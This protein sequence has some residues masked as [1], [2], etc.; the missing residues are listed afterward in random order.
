MVA[1]PAG[2]GKTTLLT[3]WLGTDA[4]AKP[5]P[6]VAWVSLDGRDNDLATFWTYVVAALQGSDSARDTLGVAALDVL[7]SRQPSSDAAIATLVN[8]LEQLDEEVLLVL[9]DYHVIESSDI[10]E[11]MTDLIDHLPSNTHV[12]LATRTDPPLPLARLR[13]R[14]ELIEVR[15]ADLRFTG[16]EAADYLAGPMGLT[17][18]AARG[19]SP[20]GSD[21]RVGSSAAASRVVAPRSRRHY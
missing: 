10:H 6:V 14:G 15:S 8:D 7:H 18:T 11:A 2:F 1:A 17:L 16:D 12:I 3:Q 19:R 20:G 21:G 4:T 9:D 5:P 13:A